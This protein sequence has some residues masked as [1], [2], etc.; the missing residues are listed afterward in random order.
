MNT[1]AIIMLGSNVN[2]DDNLELAKEKLSLQFEIIKESFTISSKPFGNNYVSDFC[3]KAIKLLSDETKEETI[4]IFK[5]I[6][7]EMGRTP[8]CKESGIM[9]IDIDLIFWNDI[10][11]HTDYDRFDFVR[12]CV[13][14]IK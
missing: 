8:E 3:N 5:N 11:V 12:K 10:Q 7:I 14:E 13:N 1:T 6:E 4:S 9:P 2:A